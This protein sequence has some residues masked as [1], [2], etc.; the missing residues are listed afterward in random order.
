MSNREAKI[1]TDGELDAEAKD[2]L[3]EVTPI[4]FDIANGLTS[5]QEVR[6]VLRELNLGLRQ[7]PLPGGVRFE[8]PAL[9]D[10]RVCFTVDFEN[11][12]SSKSSESSP[13]TAGV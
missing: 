5:I 13:R 2:F 7:L 6:G 8:L 1:Y 3:K 10:G 4:L 11:L 9:H 12:S